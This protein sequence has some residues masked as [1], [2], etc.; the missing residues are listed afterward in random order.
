MDLP[1]EQQDA[2]AREYA[3]T[4]VEA[5]RD[6]DEPVVLV[7]HSMGGV[8]IPLVP[9]LRPV[10]RMIFIGALMPIPGTSIAEQRS[11][12]PMSFPYIGGRAGLR[13][14][15]YNACTD[16]D[17]DWAMSMM[18]PQSPR[19]LDEVTPLERWPAVESSY[20]L[21][22][23]DHATNPEWSRQAARERLGTE[24]V[25]LVGS[26]HSPFLSRPAEL[27]SVLVALATGAPA[28]P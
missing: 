5:L 8:S 27:A 11:R 20:I 24:A 7:G 6:V 14:R 15:F 1:C 10:L 18:R 4:I 23:E 26:D 21:G 19:P 25:E 16:A 3:A 28:R 22:T 13:D 17:A 9:A 2:G 12:E